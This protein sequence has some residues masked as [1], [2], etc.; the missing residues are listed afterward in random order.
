MSR[1]RGLVAEVNR[2][3]CSLAEWLLNQPSKLSLGWLSRENG[4]TAGAR[5]NEDLWKKESR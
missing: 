3:G 2:T 4:S 1:E 5:E